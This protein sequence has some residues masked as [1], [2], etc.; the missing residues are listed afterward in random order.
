MSGNYSESS[1]PARRIPHDLAAQAAQ[2]WLTWLKQQPGI[3]QV[4]IAGS[5]RRRCAEVQNIDLIAASADPGP[6]MKAF[7]S[8]PEIRSVETMSED[9]SSVTTHQG[10]PVRLWIQSEPT[11][12]SLLQFA[13]GS[14]L[15]NLRLHRLARERGLT[16]TQWG[17]SG[18]SHP[19]YCSQ[20]AEVYDVLGLPWIPPEIR[21]DGREV[22][23]ALEGRLPKLVEG[24]DLTADLHMHT[25][26]SDGNAS[27]QEMAE[28]AVSLGRKL[29]AIT[30]HSASRFI[31]CGLTPQDLREQRNEIDRVQQA[32][33]R[34]LRIL[35]GVEV[36]ILPDGNLALPDS[37]LAS[38]DIV[39]ASLHFELH[40]PRSQVTR[41]LVNAIK[42]PHVDVIAH[43]SGREQPD[44]GAD[45]D[46]DE[47]FAAARE[48]GTALEIN[49]NPTH[50]DMDEEHAR[51]AGEL[52]LLIA[53]NTDAHRAPYQERYPNGIKI[54]RRAWLSPEQILTTWPPDSILAWLKSRGNGALIA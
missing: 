13:T 23:V 12:G 39:V 6:V 9:F 14:K 24:K 42:N 46:W 30:D 10:I 28:K 5:I 47:V 17:F 32:F 4:E 41:R 15:H 11:F 43:P 29:I 37:V 25:G 31:S 53:I 51:Q 21:E 19:I 7:A 49:S 48:H 22:D 45:I 54:A 18:N 40:Q 8:H 1:R 26:Y 50:L 3:K 2:A 44:P 36:D 33:G 38:L 35:Q 52:G 20:E 27:I 34:N 16:F